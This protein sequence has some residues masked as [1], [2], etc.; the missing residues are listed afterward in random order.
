MKRLIIALMAV[1]LMGV[2]AC[3]EGSE[4]DVNMTEHWKM[5]VNGEKTEL[6]VHEVADG[7]CTGCGALVDVVDGTTYVLS[8]DS[9]GN[10]R[11][12][13]TYAPDGECIVDF[14]YERTYHENG[15]WESDFVYIQGVLN[16]KVVYGY[17]NVETGEGMYA[18]HHYEYEPDGSYRVMHGD[19][20]GS[21][22]ALD[23]YS[24]SGELLYT[25]DVKMNYGGN[26]AND[27]SMQMWD[28]EVLAEEILYCFDENGA[29]MVDKYYKM[30][31]LVKEDIYTAVQIK[32]FHMGYISQSITYHADGTQTSVYYDEFGNMIEE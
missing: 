1:L 30:G 25:Y 21:V 10:I 13:L 7:R 9:Y 24:A 32:D 5:D 26:S 29:P 19:T 20:N 8:F 6:G 22:Y 11:D 27:Y 12:D 18:A 14:H 17:A 3:A 31:E 15:V 23:G 16:T 4:W 2:C 28:G